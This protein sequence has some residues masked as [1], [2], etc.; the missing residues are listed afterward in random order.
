M[1]D[2]SKIASKIVSSKNG[3]LTFKHDVIVINWETADPGWNGEA[4]LHIDTERK[5]SNVKYDLNQLIGASGQDVKYRLSPNAYGHK[6]G[7]LVGTIYVEFFKGGKP[8]VDSKE[9][10]AMKFFALVRRHFKANGYGVNG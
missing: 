1:I 9:F 3:T 7:K 5:L 10:D 6:S 2:I 4:D 8:F